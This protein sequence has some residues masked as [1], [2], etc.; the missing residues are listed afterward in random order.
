MGVALV[1]TGEGGVITA[2]RDVYG[3]C[4]SALKR[5]PGGEGGGG[6]DG[7][8]GCD[9]GNAA[10]ILSFTDDGRKIVLLFI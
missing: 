4:V 6:G 1:E 9:D 3:D 2:H 10:S 7:G 5:I 8:G